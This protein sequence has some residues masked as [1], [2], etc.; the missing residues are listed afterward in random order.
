MAEEAMVRIIVLVVAE[1]NTSL[2]STAE[3]SLIR[4]RCTATDVELAE[5]AAAVVGQ[6]PLRVLFITATDAELA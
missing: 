2:P 6:L 3:L 4:L 1:L 5:N